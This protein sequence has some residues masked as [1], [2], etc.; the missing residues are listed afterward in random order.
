MSVNIYRTDALCGVSCKGFGPVR[1]NVSAVRAVKRREL[2]QM[3]DAYYARL[4]V[5]IT[6]LER[7]N[8]FW[9]I[10]GL[11]MFLAAIFSLT[12]N[13]TAQDTGVFAP[14]TTVEARIFILRDSAGIMRGKMTVDSDRHPLLEFYDLD[15]N[16]TWSTEART[17]PTK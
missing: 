1:S 5:R 6:K 15:G 16:V 14:K 8:R 4:L 10:A 17:I 9:K 13:V 12:A 7:Q 3:T 11:L 2:M